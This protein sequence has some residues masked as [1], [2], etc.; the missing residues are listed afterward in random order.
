MTEP[1]DE[2]G[3]PASS[4]ENE[5]A[6]VNEAFQT[7]IY[8]IDHPP[9]EYRIIKQAVQG[10]VCL[11]NVNTSM[12][13][14]ILQKVIQVVQDSQG[15]RSN[16][17]RYA[18]RSLGQIAQMASETDPLINTAVDILSKMLKRDVENSQFVR[19]AAFCALSRIGRRHPQMQSQLIPLFTAY[20]EMNL[21][22]SQ[23]WGI[24]IGMGRMS[25][26][27]PILRAAWA[28]KWIEACRSSE[29]RIRWAGIK[30]L[31]HACCSTGNI[32]NDPNLE[33][34]TFQ[35]GVEFLKYGKLAEDAAR[36]PIFTGP[37][38][39][40]PWKNEDVY[41]VQYAAVGSLGLLLR[42]N[43]DEWW[44]K[45]SPV[46]AEVMISPRYAA[47]VKASVM[48]TYGKLS[49][50]MSNDNPFY[51]PLQNLLFTLC[52]YDNVL[53]S[54]PACYA[55]VNF[56]LTHTELYPKVKALMRENI[57]GCLSKADDTALLYHLKSWC[58]M[59]AKDYTPVL[60]LCA[61]STFSASYI[62]FPITTGPPPT[63]PTNSHRSQNNMNPLR[64]S[65]PRH[66]FIPLLPPPLPM[67]QN[68]MNFNP[69]YIPPF[70]IHQYP[71]PPQM[72]HHPN[73]MH[74]P[75]IR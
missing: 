41:L 19:K 62:T 9:N 50:Y 43:P 10:L 27:N 56:S 48:L 46:L 8:L 67:M 21:K 58:K 65:P 16:P 42:S 64:P 53:I 23:R 54:E 22:S 25:Q 33:L 7:C 61:N 71:Y 4:S 75:F 73:H 35:Y 59:L 57:G 74:Q 29:F 1:P 12:K 18:V 17:R 55:L 11:W 72:Q 15:Y 39:D 26:T 3:D 68:P 70:P 37:E 30:G 49:F 44:P 63:S 40:D 47:M 45:I 52:T 14:A 32:I 28:P 66:N 6:E 60:N 69:G 24:L 5:E 20:N 38:K 2:V 13:A 36:D 34:I 31:G 51:V